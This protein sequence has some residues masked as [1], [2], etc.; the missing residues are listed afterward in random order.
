MKNSHA[1]AFGPGVGV[2]GGSDSDTRMLR[3][4]GLDALRASAS[5]S[6]KHPC[7]LRLL[8]HMIEDGQQRDSRRRGRIILHSLCSA[9][10]IK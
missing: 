5:C 4:D 9:E 1:E 3:C 7:S 8:T 10:R 2:A 6:A